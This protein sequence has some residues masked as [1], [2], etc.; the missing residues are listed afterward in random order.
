M[1][2]LFTF[3]GRLGRTAFAWRLLC[4]AALLV[5][6]ICLSNVAVG[7]DQV[8]LSGLVRHSLKSLGQQGVVFGLVGV[9]MVSV[10]SIRRGRD[11]GMQPQTVLFMLWFWPSLASFSPGFAGYLSSL[12][13]NGEVLLT[14][15]AVAVYPVLAFWPSK[16]SD[17][18]VA[19]EVL[20]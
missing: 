20:A 13:V 2:S 16:P 11:I 3:Q 15:L 19:S 12:G 4:V 1:G 17:A 14:T 18:M 6:W 8:V 10:L 7:G 9:F 5:G